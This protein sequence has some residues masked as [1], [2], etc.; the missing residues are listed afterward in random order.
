MR[1]FPFAIALAAATL[2]AAIG[3]VGSAQA[4]HGCSRA[5]TGALRLDTYLDGKTQRLD[6]SFVRGELTASEY[7]ESDAIAAVTEELEH[8]GWTESGAVHDDYY[9]HPFPYRD[10]A[11]SPFWNG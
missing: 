10:M 7:A 8:R 1:D 5:S 2:L 9:D 6:V 3:G 11:D 4:H